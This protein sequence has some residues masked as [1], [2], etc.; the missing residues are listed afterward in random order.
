MLLGGES[1]ALAMYGISTNN[2]KYLGVLLAVRLECFLS[3]SNIVE[4]ILNL[5][6]S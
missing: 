5:E 1:N 3:L 6:T 4:E 2:I